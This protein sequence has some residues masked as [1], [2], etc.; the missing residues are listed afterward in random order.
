[1]R[2]GQLICK[3]I[4]VYPENLCI[5]TEVEIGAPLGLLDFN[6]NTTGKTLQYRRL[7]DII[8]QCVALS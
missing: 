2:L 3:R 5:I 4:I 1:M 8:E 7:R 6:R